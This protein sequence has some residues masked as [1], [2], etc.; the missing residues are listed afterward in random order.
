SFILLPQA[1]FVLPLQNNW[2]YGSSTFQLELDKSKT[3]NCYYQNFL[4]KFEKQQISVKNLVRLSD[5]ALKLCGVDTIGA[6]QTLHDYAK[7][8]QN[9]FQMSGM[10]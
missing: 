7:K 10:W 1:P 8:Y 5:D 9:T 2:A 4:H 3:T 6:H